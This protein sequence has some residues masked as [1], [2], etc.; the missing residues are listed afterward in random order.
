LFRDDVVDSV[1][2]KAG[3]TVEK[4]AALGRMVA[5]I[6][7]E[8]NSPVGIS[9]IL[10]GALRGSLQAEIGYI[11]AGLPAVE[12]FRAWLAITRKR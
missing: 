3:C 5:G 8:V 1:Q 7:H 2:A 9:L 4:L 12:N 11:S 6:A 10:I